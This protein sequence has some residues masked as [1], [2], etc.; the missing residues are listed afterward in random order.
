MPIPPDDPPRET[1]P[2]A[3]RERL[4]EPAQPAGPLAIEADAR[5][6]R[7]V[8][9][10]GAVSKNGYTYRSEALRQAAGLYESKPVFLDH[11][12]DPSQ[13]RS[14][15]ARD[16]VGTLTNVTYED[17]PQPRLRGDV[18]VLDTES[19][20]TFLALCQSEGSGVG[21]SHVVLARRSADGREVEAIEQ[22]VSVDAVAFPATTTSFRE[23]AEA[24]EAIEA[25]DA[26]ADGDSAAQATAESERLRR[27][28]ADLEQQLTRQRR[29]H[30]RDKLIADSGLPAAAISETF[31]RCV[32]AAATDEAAA[33]LIADRRRLLDGTGAVALS[34]SRPDRGPSADAAFVAAIRRR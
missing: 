3:V 7:R 1:R 23:Q 13:P 15:S 21:M 30:R 18:R 4:T 17:G 27:H 5:L 29:T 12:A 26:H 33:E 16:L 34:E 20:R 6:V 14:R 24:I 25:A 2:V 19:G 11:A 22:V 28:I 31:R 9:I 8:A 32:R 10:A